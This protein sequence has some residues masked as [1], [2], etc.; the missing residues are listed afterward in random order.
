VLILVRKRGGKLLEIRDLMP[1]S[2][3]DATEGKLGG[4]DPGCVAK[5]AQAVESTLVPRDLSAEKC[6]KSS[7]V[8][9]TT[10]LE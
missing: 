5:S 3:R 4:G 6:E 8:N 9:E 10:G 2:G 7:Q 1:E